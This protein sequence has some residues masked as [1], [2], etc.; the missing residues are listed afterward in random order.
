MK[1]I[2]YT[3]F[4]TVIKYLL[5]DIQIVMSF[6]NDFPYQELYK[7]LDITYGLTV[8]SFEIF[9]IREN[10]KK[11]SVNIFYGNQQ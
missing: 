3:P 7:I 1:R 2:K 10:Q 9:I 8:T 11:I 6:E 5:R 4:L